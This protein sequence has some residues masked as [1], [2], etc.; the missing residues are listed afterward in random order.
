MY[1]VAIFLQKIQSYEVNHDILMREIADCFSNSKQFEKVYRDVDTTSKSKLKDELSQSFHSFYSLHCADSIRS[2][3]LS[4]D[5]KVDLITKLEV[6]K[7]T[8]TFIKAEHLLHSSPQLAC[9]LSILFNG[10]LQHG[11][12]P[13]DFLKSVISPVIKNLSGDA[14]DPENYRC[15]SIGSLLSQL[16]ECALFKKFQCFISTD[17]LLFGYKSKH[18]ANRALFYL[19]NLCSTLL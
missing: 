14:T 1:S 18:S 9:H 17:D 11:F 12:V 16:F 10:L 8:S 15:I 5:D 13:T 4:I 7:S 19:T 2:L 3:F 6:G